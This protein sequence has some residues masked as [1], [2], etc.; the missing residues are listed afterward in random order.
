VTSLT[1]EERAHAREH[2]SAMRARK[3]NFT[4]PVQWAQVEP[5]KVKGQ[6][7]GTA[8]YNIEEKLYF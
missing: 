2:C 6:G 8:P 5:K 3:V 7:D 1:I 4:V